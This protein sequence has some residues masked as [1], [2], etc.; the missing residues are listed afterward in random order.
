MSPLDCGS[1]RIVG[2]RFS[3][4]PMSDRFVDIILGVLERVDRS[5][6]WMSTDDISTCIRGKAVHVFD[7]AKAVYVYAA[8]TGNH[9]VWNGTFSVGCPGD[10]EGDVYLSED[11]ER[12][13][14]S[15]LQQHSIETA[16]QF[17]LY[18]LGKPDYMQIIYEQIERAKARGTFSGGAHYAS[19]LDGDAHVVFATLEE[20][21]V[22]ASERASHV[23]M[24]AAISANSP[25][26]K[27]DR[28]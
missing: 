2:C 6:V 28:G 24:T 13:N 16:C 17:A 8:A 9:V 26:R 15:D 18:P 7:V 19:R 22:Q 10:G 12:M 21:F 5:K 4:Y 3:L 23:T 20:A 27:P 25:S 11:E 14:E 1:S